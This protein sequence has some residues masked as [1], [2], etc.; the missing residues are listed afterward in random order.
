[1]KIAI[2]LAALA[3]GASAAPLPAW[4]GAA[5][6]FIRY[7]CGDLVVVG[8]IETIGYADVEE[9]EELPFRGWTVARVDISKV[10]A[11]T[12]EGEALT[13]EYFGH[14]EFRTD[15]D[16]VLVVYRGAGGRY[17]IRSA[18]LVEESRPPRLAPACEPRP[19]G[20]AWGP[21]R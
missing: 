12:A 4:P 13:I 17:L 11:G 2:L 8:R 9:E 7:G 6:G 19:L 21:A 3:S 5:S 20:R 15:R 14:G 1:M 18:D 16:F 10:L